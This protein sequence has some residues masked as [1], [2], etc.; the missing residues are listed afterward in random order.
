MQ[1]GG[2]MGGYLDI[3]LAY[4]SVL[5]HEFYDMVGPLPF[6]ILRVVF[7]GLGTLM[8]VLAIVPRAYGYGPYRHFR[9][10]SFG[11]MVQSVIYIGLGVL[12]L[13]VEPRGGYY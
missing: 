3:F 7:F 2:E 5:A 11:R 12:L 8:F 6:T 9:Y 13:L 4:A 10:F 1:E